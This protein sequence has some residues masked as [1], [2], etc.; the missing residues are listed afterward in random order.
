MGIDQYHV[1]ELVGEGSFGKVYKGRRKYTGQTVAMKFILKHGKSD[2]DIENLRQEIEILRQLKHENIIEMLD[3]FESPQEFCVVTEFAQGELFEILEDDKCLP[4][5]QVQAI[6][7]QLVR[8]LHYLHSHRIIHRDMKPQNILIGAGG[9]VKLCDFGFARAMSCNTM[10]LRSIKGTPLYMAPE[11]VREQ[12]YNHTADLWSLG[13]ILYELYVG[14]PPF[15]TNSVYTLIRH[16]VKDPVKYPDTISANFRSFL[17]GLLNKV[18]Q[19]RLT[20]PGLLD[21]PF[22]RETPEELA[23]REARAATAAARGC[24]AAWRGEVNI[25]LASPVAVRT[26]AHSQAA[27]PAGKTRPPREA[28]T[29]APAPETPAATS[30]ALQPSN[31]NNQPQQPPVSPVNQP[32]PNAAEMSVLDK[33]E[34]SSRSVKGAQAVGQD[35]GALAHVL[36]AFRNLQIK[37]SAALSRQEN[38]NGQRS[39]NNNDE[40]SSVNASQ[41]LRI[42]SNLLTSCALQQ[43]TAVEDAIPAVLGLVRATLGASNGQHVGLLIKGLAVLR[44]L[45]EVG[46]ATVE[47][48]Y[49]HHSV[50]ILRLYPQ[51]VAYAD[52]SSGRVLY[53]STSCVAVLLTRVVT[54]LANLLAAD[55]DE[56]NQNHRDAGSDEGQ[57][58]VQILGQAKAV[59]TADHLCSC[60]ST[61]GT[62]LISATST[63]APA[64]GE[65]CKGL[66]ALINGMNLTSSK[67]ERRYGFPLAVLKGYAEAWAADK[68][69]GEDEN[70]RAEEGSCV[71]VRLVTDCISKSKSVQVA[72]C[73]ALLHGSDVALS[74][75]MQVLLRCCVQSPLVC[76]VLAGISTQEPPS[77]TPVSGGGDGTAVGAIFRVL[78]VHGPSSAPTNN[79]GAQEP[80]T[81]ATEAAL[82]VAAEGLMKQAC[83]ALAAIAQGL[84]AQGRRGASCMLSGSQPK[85]RARLSALAHQSLLDTVPKTPLTMSRCASAVLALSSILNLEQGIDRFGGPCWVSELVLPLLPPFSVIR[86]SLQAPATLYEDKEGNQFVNKSGSGMLTSWHGLRDGYIGVLDTRLRWGGSLAV[87][88]A[89][90]ASFPY[91]LVSLLAGGLTGGGSNEPGRHGEDLIGLSP[92][93]V[94]WALSA[95]AHCLSGG[96]FHDVL[97]RREPLQAIVAL[98]DQKHLVHVQSWEGAGGGDEGMRETVCGVVKVLE[99]PF[100]VSQQTAAPGSPTSG[101][102]TAPNS[103]GARRGDGADLGK[104]INASMPLYWQLLQEVNVSAPLIKSLEMLNKDDLGM[105]VALIAKVVQSSRVLAG[106]LVR[107]G[108]LSSALMSKLLDQA[109]PKDVLRDVLMTVSNLARLSKDFYEPIGL[110]NIW[111]A[112]KIYMSH[113][114]PSLR[115]KACSVLGNMCRHT[116]YFYEALVQHDIINLLI[117]R[118]ADPDRHTRKFACFGLGNAAYHN[119]V[120]YDQL[121]RSIPHLTSLLQGDEEDKTKANAAGALSNLVRNSNKLCEDIITK[122]AMQA[123]CQ[124][125]ADCASATPGSDRRAAS[126]SESPLKI[127]LF[128]LGNMCVHST[129]RQYLRSPELFRVLLKLKQSSDATV[130]KY[131]TRI[132]SKFPD[133]SANNR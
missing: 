96:G 103:P 128:S 5:G 116:P 65:A 79:G 57:I 14:Q 81:A 64:A 97:L 37:G 21:H 122:G 10:V 78:S 44:K 6:A 29:P 20:W 31:K 26:P 62:S 113:A 24:D 118:C 127:A 105:P 121:R 86:G 70:V 11:L 66:W 30:P 124:V 16:I 61:A 12:P 27:S 111:E 7:K 112:L 45:M 41:G 17:K 22:V 91:G 71:V 99:F 54:G 114:D 32:P 34:V 75:V 55:H 38:T 130:V 2:K 28:P 87:E 46:G 60:L 107:Q 88:Q 101:T 19:N 68:K 42:L 18:S 13:V 109:C 119:D 82:K 104:V 90:S 8:A 110:A 95:I 85:Q 123:L 89:C 58:M 129:C 77:Q 115:S 49:L 133:S 94:V 39:V 72:V 120:L 52:D 93:G 63:S 84:L 43:K 76:D 125:I 1:L 117:D 83:L 23:A 80:G 3:A 106:D 33:V 48:S 108:L 132:T 35:R 51:A 59:G 50:A 36:H 98:I 9:I 69:K 92:K 56:R 102:L 73:Y 67:G 47:S 25:T 15:Y 131:V 40:Q 53:E 126:N 4:E 74:A 100:T